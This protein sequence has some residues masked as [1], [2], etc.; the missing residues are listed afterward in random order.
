MLFVQCFLGFGFL[1]WTK[2]V[3]AIA[4]FHTFNGSYFIHFLVILFDILDL[5]M[6]YVSPRILV[7]L[8]PSK[9]VT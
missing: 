2:Y 7:Y 9:G 5:H 1:S 6:A 8:H 3:Y 4:Y